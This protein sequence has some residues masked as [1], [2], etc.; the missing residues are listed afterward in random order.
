[1]LYVA[2]GELQCKVVSRNLSE[3]VTQKPVSRVHGP[4]SLPRTPYVVVYIRMAE[5]ERG[6]LPKC[7]DSDENFK[8]EHTLF[9]RELRF[10]AIYRD[11]WA[12]KLP[13]WVKNGVS[14]AISALIH[15][16]YYIFY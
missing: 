14:W 9:C 11:L 8:P 1:M 7:L 6:G 5:V 13:F 15:D 4:A 3:V 10:A 16:K 2:H 12:K